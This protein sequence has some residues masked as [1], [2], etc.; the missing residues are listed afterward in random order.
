MQTMNYR[1]GSWRAEARVEE[2]NPGKLMA[3]ISMD[4]DQ[5]NASCCSRHT[6]V[7]E[8]EEGKDHREQ[9]KMLVHRLL[10]QRYGL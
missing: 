1:I 8:N 2:V 6:V 9:T 4:N 10:H 7:F 5:D 3:V